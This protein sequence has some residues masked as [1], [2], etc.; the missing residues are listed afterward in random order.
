MKYLPLVWAGIWRKRARTILLLLQIATAFVLF[1]TLQGLSSGIKQVISQAH[2][3]RLFITSRIS[4]TGQTQL[5]VSLLQ[6]VQ[7]IHGVQHV[8]P[9]VALVG[10][11]QKS[12]QSVPVIATDVDEFLQIYDEIHVSA[13]AAAALRDSRASGIAGAA[14]MRQYGWKVGDRVVLQ[15]PLPKTDGT[16]DWT[17]DLVGSYD[18]PDHPENA[19]SII[20]NYSYI[21]ESR[22][23]DRDRANMLVVK[24]D[25]PANAGTIG[26]AID[27]GFTNSE[28]ET[29]TQSEADRL[30][31]QLQQTV[32][33]DY[34]VRAIVGAIFFALLLAT[35]A[36]MMQSVRERGSEL[37]VLKTLGFSDRFVLL[38][39]LA[40]AVLQCVFAAIVGLALAFFVLPRVRPELTQIAVTQVPM[41]VIFT[42]IG[43]A[44]LLALISA[45]APA[46][47]GSRRP[48]VHALAKR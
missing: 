11:F 19:D 35:G 18:I 6:N 9:E 26:L 33:L 30:A 31:A 48:I 7:A 3:D 40:E 13:G 37:A 24:V 16:R 38:L 43:F 2:V 21:N 44:A 27:T 42:G 14:L 1:G 45:Y 29:R 28:H 39:I 36:L 8:T 23:T 22:L 15:T 25:D 34:I 20:A 47:Q 41:I 17:F 10:T 32:D 12:D 5:P 46:L 4:A